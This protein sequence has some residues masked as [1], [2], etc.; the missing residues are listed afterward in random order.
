MTK[1]NLAGGP[2]VADAKKRIFRRNGE[3]NRERRAKQTAG[4]PGAKLRDFADHEFSFS[5]WRQTFRAGLADREG[6]E[7]V[8]LSVADYAALFG[9]GD[10]GSIYQQWALSYK[11]PCGGWCPKGRQAED[12]LLRQPHTRER[13]ER[14]LKRV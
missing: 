2:L 7:P 13:G 6:I 4:C 12:G 3:R 8:R 14:R 10:H 9:R 11:L 5:A 1:Q